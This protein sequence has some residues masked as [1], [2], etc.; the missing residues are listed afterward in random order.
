M[1]FYADLHIHSKFSRATSR[2]CDLEH[3]ACWAARK[4]I[5][6]LGTGD[7]TH[8]GWFAEIRTKLVPDGA[9]LFR[10]RDELVHALEA[11]AGQQPL[12][13]E[14]AG[15][16]SLGAVRFMLQVEISTI[17]KRDDRTRKVH[18]LIYVPDLQKAEVLCRRLERIGNI[19]SDGRPILGLDSR[20]LMAMVCELGDDCYLIPAHI[21]TPWFAVLGS[22]SG[23]DAIK[24]CYGPLSVRIFAVETGLSSDPPM[25]WR[26]SA[27]DCYALVSNSD[28]HSPA[29]L[30]REACR[31][32]T[33]CAYEAVFAALR[34]REGYGGTIEFFAE[35]GKYHFDGHRKCGICFSPAETRRS[36][37]LCPACGKPLTLGV[38]HRVEQLADR[39]AEPC[40]APRG[41]AP[42]RSLVPLEEILSELLGVGTASKQVAQRYDE[43]LARLGPELAILEHVPLEDIRAAGGALLAEAIARLRTG[44]VRRQPGYDGQYGT[45]R[46]F[47]PAELARRNSAGLLFDLPEVE[48]RSPRTLPDG[49]FALPKPTAALPEQATALLGNFSPGAG[50]S[51]LAET[52]CEQATGLLGKVAPGKDLAAVKKVSTPATLAPR[53]AQ[54]PNLLAAL[55]ADQQAAARLVEG[56]LVIIAGPGTGKTR[57]L[58]HRIAH[59]V[60]D[61][62]AK[63]EECLAITFTR[64]AA[65]E[66]RRRLA[67]LLPAAQAERLP[68]LTF[69]ALGYRLLCQYGARLGLV[70][71]LRVA[72]RKQSAGLLQEIFALSPRRAEQLTETLSRLRRSRAADEHKGKQARENDEHPAHRQ[73]Q[74]RLPAQARAYEKALRARGLVDLDDLLVLPVELLR[75]HVDIREEVRAAYRWVS[76]DEFQDVEP[77]QYE[78]LRLMV[79]PEGNLCVI[80]DPDQAIYGFRGGDVGCFAQFAADFPTARRVVLKRNYRTIGPILSAALEMIAPASLLGARSLQA[81]LDGLDRVEIHAAAT[82][83]AEAELVVHTI[84]RMIG[85]STFFSLDSGRVEAGEGGG[86]SFADF[87]ILYR[88]EA[89]ADVLVEALARSGMPFRRHS[90][91]WLAEQPA[92][93]RLLGELERLPAE[94]PLAERIEQVAA[95][96]GDELPELATLREP[97]KAL[98][99]RCG[100]D[101]G[102]FRAELALGVDV[103]LWDP[104]ADRVALLTLHA[105]KGLEFPVVFI[106]GCEDGLLPLRFGMADRAR[107]TEPAKAQQAQHAP[108]AEQTTNAPQAPWAQR[109]AD[110]EQATQSQ[111]AEERR[112]LFVGMTR[113]E[114]RLILTWARRRF[115]QG[116]IRPRQPSPFLAD[117]REHLLARHEHR[118]PLRRSKDKDTSQRSLFEA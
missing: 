47:D 18:H 37:G 17:Y 50:K 110:T 102:Q 116:R 113:A 39:P 67:G 15:A 31:F 20:E 49:A 42:F 89:Q 23:F 24:E 72:G 101:C 83:R 77:R 5:R 86:L 55:D 108:R 32:Q 12:G 57:T 100:N 66:M 48:P 74:E 54:T 58:T 71:P 106:V 4:G 80:G 68:V 9:G 79:P 78:L 98:A 53:L 34:T 76:V 51:T 117:I 11:R 30:G 36:Q 90:H 92:L 21:W 88:T 8:P 64:R 56:P 112:L 33:E 73:R 96:V 44:Q 61:H 114:R 1:E 19:A 16:G 35:E 118:A 3:L 93:E 109:A 22:K 94:L 46:L 81:A 70:E 14:P 38:M 59:L 103:D 52:A 25:N 115:W 87:A 107:K 69:H 95:A 60:A 104:R 99:E 26:L 85:G 29:K 43:L 65:E 62:G 91:R 111:L 10:L 45:I 63:P 84:E 27:L 28:A 13:A 40:A 2:D 97:L 82:E 6:L 105:A 7:F 75:G 41:A